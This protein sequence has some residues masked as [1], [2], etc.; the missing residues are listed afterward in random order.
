MN[1]LN[2]TLHDSSWHELQISIKV[3]HLNEKKSKPIKY[4]PDWIGGSDELFKLNQIL[5]AI[6][7]FNFQANNR[8]GTW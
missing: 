3:E 2:S 7:M 5:Q 6:K 1:K 4:P 8:G